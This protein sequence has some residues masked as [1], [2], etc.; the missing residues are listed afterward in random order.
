VVS[1]TGT[2]CQPDIPNYAGRDAFRG[3]QLHSVRCRRPDDF[4]GQTVLI[5][6]GGNSGAQIL[7]EVCAPPTDAARKRASC[8]ARVTMARARRT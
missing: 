5:V 3:R 8:P 1:A 2:W 6:G 4:A 7:A